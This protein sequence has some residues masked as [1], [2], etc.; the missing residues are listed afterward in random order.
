MNLLDHYISATVLRGFLLIVA[1]L[2]VLFSLLAFVEQLG[3][4]GQGHYSAK[5]ALLCVLLTAP[6]RVVQIT[7]VAM[8]LGALLALGGLARNSELIA[9]RALGVSETQ[10]VG[11][12]MK[13]AVPIA[14]A[15][16]LIAQFV[17]PPGQLMAQHVQAAASGEEAP[18]RSAGGFWVEHD[19]QYL[20]VQRFGY[21]NVP[22]SIDIYTFNDDGS[23]NSY[24]HAKRAE[25]EPDGTWMLIGVL[26]KTVDATH[27]TT[28]TLDALP[29]PSF[30]SSHQLRLLMLPPEM[31]PPIALYRYIGERKRLD[32]QAQRDELTFW[33]MVS[34][35]L[36]LF[37]M[38]MIAA[39][40]VFG[41]QRMQGAG[42]Q[43]LIG[44]LLGI[45][46]QVGQQVIFYLGLRLSLNPA[47][48]ALAPSV[49]LIGCAAYLIRRMQ[50]EL[51]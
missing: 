40:F 47:I 18:L 26:Q 37:G 51:K 24:T 8:L 16:F 44:A 7:P 23:L 21:G 19:R 12:L 33:T 9:F 32:Q 6:Y 11:A 4:V 42:R 30:I 2:T 41:V 35:P 28:I 34:V 48:T 27:F 10:I 50:V 29:W 39:P 14:V 3:F 17:I 1:V 20:N 46:F 43:L 25:V 31:M 13:L 15:L 45:G 36:S 5:D 38:A 49:A 22:E